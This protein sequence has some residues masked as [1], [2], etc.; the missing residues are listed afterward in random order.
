MLFFSMDHYVLLGPP[1]I[2]VFSFLRS[3]YV[4][5]NNRVSSIYIFYAGMSDESLYVVFFY[6]AYLCFCEKISF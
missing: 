5:M 6:P 4:S 1:Y 3:V 2:C